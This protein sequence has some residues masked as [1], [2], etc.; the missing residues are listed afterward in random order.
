MLAVE[1]ISV[2]PFSP[3]VD[4]DAPPRSKAKAGPHPLISQ[5]VAERTRL[6]LSQTEIA[7]RCGWSRQNQSKLEKSA[8]PQTK[9]VERFA[10]ALGLQLAF[11]IGPR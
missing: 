3:A 5:L 4:V 10:E 1:R 6:D 2:I 8:N 11:I 7:N 9:S